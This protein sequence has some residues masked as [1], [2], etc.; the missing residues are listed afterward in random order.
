[1]MASDLPE[2]TVT[3]KN[4]IILLVTT[5]L[6]GALALTAVRAHDAP[7]VATGFVAHILCS[8][9][10]VSGL[11]PDRVFSET[12]AG[13]PGTG[14]ITW[15]LDYKIDH[16]RKDVTVTLLGGGQSRAVFREGL[17]C[18]VSHDDASVDASLPPAASNTQHALLPE[19]AG[20]TLVE[21]S[22]PQLAAALDH[23]FAEPE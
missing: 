13:M 7:R 3:P 19:I 11:D 17:G 2:N 15:A 14:L 9:T 21:P 18:Y 12:T 4:R 20:P 6:C 22:N 1:M 8:E 23:A 16:A 10:F 5:T